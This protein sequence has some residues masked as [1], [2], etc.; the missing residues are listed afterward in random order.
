MTGRRGREMILLCRRVKAARENVDEFIRLCFAD[1]LGRPPAGRVHR[2]LQAFLTAHRHGLVELPRD[3]GKSVQVCVRAAVGAGPQPGPARQG[4][5]R[6]RGAGG[7]SAAGSS[8]TPSP[9]TRGCGWCSR[10]CGRASR[11][12]R[13]GSRSAGRPT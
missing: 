9:A 1:P 7:S 11:G 4:R 13:R 10:T 12:R 5:L 6:H 2:E 8:A 3:H